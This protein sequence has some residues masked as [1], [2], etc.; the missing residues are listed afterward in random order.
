MRHPPHPPAFPLALSDH[1]KLGMSPSF[2]E[3]LQPETGKQKAEEGKG[4]NVKRRADSASQYLESA[5]DAH[6]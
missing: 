3:T 4:H 1:L 5:A 6:R 2:A